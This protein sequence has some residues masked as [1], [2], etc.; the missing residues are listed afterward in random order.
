MNLTVVQI[1]DFLHVCKSETEAFHIVYVA[2]VYP[3]ELIEHFLQVLFLYSHSRITY[4][5]IQMIVIVPRF[6][7]YVDRTILL[8]V[9]HSIVKKVVYNIL[10][11]HLINI[12]R[13]LHS[14]YI[15]IYFSTGMLHAQRKRVPPFRSNRGVSS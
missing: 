1:Y 6:Q 2:S 10:K 5:Q 14:T 9:F 11:M 15:G 7:I 4:R 13:R 12:Y 8:S 3:I